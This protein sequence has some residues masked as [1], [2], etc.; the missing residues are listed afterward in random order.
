MQSFTLALSLLVIKIVVGENIVLV[1]FDSSKGPL[2]VWEE[3]ND[4]VMGGKSTGEFTVME[5]MGVFS[6]EVVDVPFLKAPGFIQAS[7]PGPF[8][9]VSSCKALSITCRSLTNYEGYKIAFG[10]KRGPIDCS[11]F[12]RGYKTALAAPSDL[13]AVE[14]PFDLF[15]NCNDDG[16]GLPIRTCEDDPKVCPNER[17]LENLGLITVWGEG[18][19]GEVHLEI[20]RIEATQCDANRG[21]TGTSENLITIGPLA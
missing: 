20:T 19:G 14:I 16:T 7:T 18:V 8:P 11:F 9:D 6:G 2:P 10:D 1:E 13:A 5:G 3:M 15:S 12:S 17:A 21:I 4:P